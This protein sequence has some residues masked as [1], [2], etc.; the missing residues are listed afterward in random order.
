MR[1]VLGDLDT[2][3]SLGGDTAA[4]HFARAGV[5]AI[6]GDDRAARAAVEQARRLPC[7]T[8]SD[9]RYRATV[10]TIQG[11]FDDALRCYRQAIRL[12]PRELTSY[13]ELG[14]HLDLRGA[15]DEALAVL[16]QAELI[17]PDEPEIAAM[18]AWTFIQ[19]G[20]RKEG[21][22]LLEHL[23]QRRPASPRAVSFLDAV[24]CQ[25]RRF[26]E[27]LA[28][29]ESLLDEEPENGAWQRG[30]LSALVVSGHVA[31]AAS[32]LEELRANVD[33]TLAR[34]LQVVIDLHG[35]DVGKATD[36]LEAVARG[37]CAPILIETINGLS[38]PLL[39]SERAPHYG[40]FF[41][42]MNELRNLRR[43]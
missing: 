10:E 18:R 20:R 38:A 30:W 31:E 6:L 33:P 23:V 5:L 15:F 3:A 7:T 21:I 2:A 17:H 43:L 19:S 16:D 36:E 12:R 42:R 11:N 26:D 35:G 32:A 28:L 14:N 4:L 39:S 37:D 9:H 25:E 40:L 27:L 13:L 34:A 41:R 29:R 8:A 1:S 24:L 22:D